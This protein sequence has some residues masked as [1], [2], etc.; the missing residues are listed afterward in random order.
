MIKRYHKE[1]NTGGDFS[2]ALRK[3]ATIG[4]PADSS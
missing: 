3:E 1:G 2:D 4:F